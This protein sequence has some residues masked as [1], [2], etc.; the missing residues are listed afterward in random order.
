MSLKLPKDSKTLVDW[1][2]EIINE[3]NQSQEQR[4]DLIKMYKSYYFTG[5]SQGEMTFYNRCYPH[6]ERLGAFLF[7][8][9]D[10][11]FDIEFDESE[12]E[13]IHEMGYAAARK[14]NREIGRRN[15]DLAMASALNGSLIEGCNLVKLIW[16]FNGLEP[17]V[18]RPVFFGVL[19][20]DID[21]L[22]SQEAF[23]HSTY[24]TPTAFER[25]LVDHPDKDKI[26]LQIKQS[27]ESTQ[28]KQELEDSYIH[29]IIIGGTQP[30]S[31]TTSAGS[32]M[33]G[34]TGI[35]Q[36]SLD[37]KVAQSLIRVDELWVQD[38][39]RQDYTTLRLVKPDILIEGKYK[40]R[41][42]CGLNDNLGKDTELKG[43]HPFT[44]VC[45][46]EVD[47]YFWGQSEI[48]QIYK[49]QDDLNDQYRD[50]RRITRLRADPPRTATGFS[51]ITNEKYKAFNRPRG[52]ISEDNPTAKMETHAPDIP[53]EMF[54]RFDKTIQ[55]FDDVA[56]FTPV[57]QGQGEQGV[58][59]QAQAS[60]LAR[61][62]SP[63]MRDRALLIERQF[64]ELGDFCLKLLAAKDAEVQETGKEKTQFLLS[65][66]PDDARVIVDSHTSS[67][68]YQEDSERKAFMLQ[69][70]GAIDA[71]DLIM[72]TH[73]PHEDK[74]RKR[75]KA[76]A[77]AEAKFAK[78]HPELAFGK[79]K[80]K[81]K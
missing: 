18:V 55:A 26:M 79:G 48:A 60:T 81:R 74:L 53:P 34:V 12:D 58:R 38:S 72:L 39:E 61:N 25:T 42:L 65:Q 47:G 27:A 80:G 57:L 63:R 11:R 40:R 68:V 44:K 51:G 8:P 41:N 30:V 49:L 36:P 43:H 19:R 52:F 46:N 3:C 56:G 59:S 66:L 13:Q 70:A 75:A 4:R 21:D 73:P 7:S 37:A 23:V 29:Q 78:E 10:A 71:E 45:P 24:L 28:E 9:T 22:D 33:V 14:L 32:G 31:T 1:A 17:W 20:E 50:I 62:S 6:I 16:G 77:E 5:T 64:T 69:R 54:T 76:R 67:P 15:I 2:W 35:P